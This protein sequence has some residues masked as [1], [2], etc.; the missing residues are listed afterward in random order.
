M[1]KTHIFTTDENEISR[2]WHAKENFID[3]E[4]IKKEILEEI[5]KKYLKKNEFAIS[6]R[7]LNL[8]LKKYLPIWKDWSPEKFNIEE[9]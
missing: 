1:S 5:E 7:D 9:E 3:L 2:K 6:K 8:K 4:K